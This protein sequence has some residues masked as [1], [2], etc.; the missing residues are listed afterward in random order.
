VN[1]LAHRTVVTVIT[2]HRIDIALRLPTAGTYHVK[3]SNFHDGFSLNVFYD[4]N[5]GN[6]LYYAPPAPPPKIPLPKT[7]TQ[8]HS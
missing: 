1:G 3:I 2:T 6:I 7:R 4:Y 8:C 5:F